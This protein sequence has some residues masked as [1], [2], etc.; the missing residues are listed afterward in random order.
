[1]MFVHV[2]GIKHG[3]AKKG[4]GVLDALAIGPFPMEGIC[5]LDTVVEL[6]D[7]KLDAKGLT[8]DAGR[9]DSSDNGILWNKNSP[10]S[11]QHAVKA[12][13]LEPAG[14]A[15]NW[16]DRINDLLML[17]EEEEEDDDGDTDTTG[18][19]G[20]GG[21]AT[22]ALT[23]TEEKVLAK[24]I[25]VLKEGDQARDK[26]TAAKALAA[27]HKVAVMASHT[28]D[29]I[30]QNILQQKA[31]SYSWSSLSAL[32]EGEE[33]EEEEGD[34]DDDDDGGG[35][36]DCGPGVNLTQK[37][38]RTSPRLRKH[39]KV[40]TWVLQLFVAVKSERVSTGGA[41]SSRGSNSKTKLGADPTVLIVH[42]LSPTAKAKGA[43]GEPDTV[44]KGHN[45]EEICTV[46]VPVV[47]TNSKPVTTS[48]IRKIVIDAY[49]HRGIGFDPMGLL[50]ESKSARQKHPKKIEKS[51]D[52]NLGG[53]ATT[54]ETMPFL[55]V[56]LRMS[57]AHM[58][59]R[60]RRRMPR[61]YE[62][63]TPRTL[64]WHDPPSKG[65]QTGRLPGKT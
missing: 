60:M 9:W 10:T 50:Y 27:K 17:E 36:D 56:P 42:V 12:D 22:A 31:P 29:K 33:E 6:V 21:N 40:N 19:D 2:Y 25:L 43:R 59:P 11:P 38:A 35:G 4:R 41:G 44:T 28:A 18:G 58:T 46:D 16:L 5:N 37:P 23:S 57:P 15:H 20:E 24:K 55:A 3:G 7:E 48:Q 26:K 1:M 54:I 49:N 53:K 39:R 52:L 61:L 51:T 34:D 64:A 30:L 63:I 32:S 47:M 65:K 13:E 62:P 8:R 14:E 45:S